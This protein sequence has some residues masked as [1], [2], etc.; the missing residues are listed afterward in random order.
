MNASNAGSPNLS[1]ILLKNTQHSTITEDKM[2]I[3][4]VYHPFTLLKNSALGIFYS[5]RLC[6]CKY[7]NIFAPVLSTFCPHLTEILHYPLTIA[8]ICAT[9]NSDVVCPNKN[10]C[11]YSR[12]SPI[13]ISAL[14][15]LSKFLFVAIGNI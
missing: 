7:Y 3:V 13:Y 15:S 6:L 9:I 10:A 8:N 1:D 2:S 12:R 14:L 4:V 5:K 11:L